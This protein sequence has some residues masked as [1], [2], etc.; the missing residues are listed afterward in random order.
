M[1]VRRILR[2]CGLGAA[3]ALAF[4]GLTPASAA[5]PG[6]VTLSPTS[7]PAG[8][9]VAFSGQDCPIDTTMGGE[10]THIRVYLDNTPPQSELRAYVPIQADGSFSGSF[11]FP[12]SRLVN[13]VD[14]PFD[15]GPQRVIFDCTTYNYA[16][17]S[18]VTTF[19]LTTSATTAPTSPTPTTP[20]PGTPTPGGFHPPAAPPSDAIPFG[21]ALPKTVMQGGSVSLKESGFAPG[22]Q[23]V[24]V[25][26]SA[27]VVLG[28]AKAD[29]TGTLSMTVRIPSSTTVGKHTLALFGATTVK[30]GTL[31]VAAVDVYTSPGYHD[32]NGRRWHT[33]C[34][35][36]SQTTRCRTE[37]WSTQVV[38]VSGRFVKANG[39]HFNNLSYLPLMKRTQWTQN[40]L[41]HPGKF[42]SADRQWYTECD[43]AATGRNGCRSFIWSTEVK[44]TQHANGTWS[45]R[46]DQGWVFNNLVRFL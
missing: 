39:W 45:Y 6:V 36:Y 28:T 10:V 7:G 40:P 21:S 19:T 8:T 25:I 33:T 30:A 14:V 1:S 20:A 3:I 44:A 4:T 31:M 27:P 32:V 9:V 22:E 35:P 38:L 26:Y 46:M 24:A 13:G 2:W 16:D 5:P 15:L 29:A 37:I 23:V 43:T 41:G 34:Q 12:A 17:E 18:I 42:T 11:I